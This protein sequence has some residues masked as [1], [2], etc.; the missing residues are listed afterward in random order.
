MKRT[1]AII[2][3]S[4]VFLSLSSF[5]P[6]LSVVNAQSSKAEI[7]QGAGLNSNGTN[8][9]APAGSPSLAGVVKAMINVLSII[10]GIIAVIMII[11]GGFKFVTSGGD[12]NNVSS[13]KSTII[14]A[15]VGLVVV[16]LA[17]VL[18]HFVLTAVAKGA[19]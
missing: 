9:Q 10:L 6:S 7:C 2:T 17:Q 19:K 3:L 1:L 5:W 4:F 15:L 14:Y 13:A 12:A 16:A 8:C 11:I 18:V